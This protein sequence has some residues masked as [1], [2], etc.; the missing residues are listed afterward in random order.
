M[1]NQNVWLLL[2][3]NRDT[4]IDGTVK[5]LLLFSVSLVFAV[6]IGIASAYITEGKKVG[7]KKIW[8][9]SVD[10]MR[11][12]PFLIFAYLLY[13]GLPSIDIRL[14]AWTS[15]LIALSLYHGAYFA[16]IFR[17]ARSSLD[18]GQ[19]DAAKAHGYTKTRMVTFII[20]PQLFLRSGPVWQINLFIYSKTP[21]F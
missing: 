7:M 18:S 5:T 13:Y 16:E 3:D 17:G 21:H 11:T 4:F 12:L 20:L 14:S 2:W 10:I 19:V 1:E 6:L 9:W 8:T 15:G